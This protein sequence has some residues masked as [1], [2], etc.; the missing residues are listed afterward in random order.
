MIILVT[1]DSLGLILK[2]VIQG[3]DSIKVG[4]GKKAVAGSASSDK[5]LFDRL[6][7]LGLT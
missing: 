7:F 6:A 1:N 5:N 3:D 4:A 2:Q